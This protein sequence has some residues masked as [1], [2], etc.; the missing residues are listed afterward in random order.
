MAIYQLG[1]KRPAS[2][3]EH[4]TIEENINPLC[5][6]SKPNETLCHLIML[7]LMISFSRIPPRDFGVC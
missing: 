3:R 2:A 4:V 5:D 6:A 1:I 7:S